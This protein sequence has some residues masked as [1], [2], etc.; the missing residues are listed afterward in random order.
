MKRCEEFQGYLID[1]VLG[2]VLP[3]SIDVELR[4]HLKHCSRCRS[5]CEE[6]GGVRQSLDKLSDIRFSGSL[7][8]NV[9]REARVIPR[10][11]RFPGRWFTVRRVTVLAAA[12]SLFLGAGLFIIFRGGPPSD[13]GDK[14]GIIDTSIFV[15]GEVPEPDLILTMEDYLNE[16]AD[17]LSGI[18][19]GRYN[20]WG[21]IIAEIISRD[22]QGR[23]NYLLENP[24]LPPS[25][26]PVIGN[27]H[28][29][30]WELLRCGRGREGDEA[31]LPP[32]VDLED[33]LSE[34]ERGKCQV[35]EIKTK[36]E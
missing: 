29:T 24:A 16:A 6:F 20:T 3:G 26:R 10:A 31:R 22:T 36:S 21:S 18:R 13:Q 2:E 33:L 1:R 9:L 8:R 25:A 4:E 14:Q 5:R 19:E 11:N 7:S 17:I 35:M 32:G 15:P 34:I 30:F 12:A 23:A 27:L 28:D